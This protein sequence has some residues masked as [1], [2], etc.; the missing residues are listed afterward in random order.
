VKQHL[1]SK[2]YTGD[3]MYVIGYTCN[4]CQKNWNFI[5]EVLACINNHEVKEM[6]ESDIKKI[7]FYTLEDSSVA[8][9]VVNYIRSWKDIMETG[10][11]SR[12]GYCEALRRLCYAEV[13]ATV[14]INAAIHS[15][16]QVRGV[17]FAQIA[18]KK[19]IYSI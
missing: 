12:D 15:I 8:D 14:D 18:G 11:L 4:I 2:R 7:V 19:N 10:Q 16:L 13:S 17:A 9:A 5:Y 1:Y 6:P 3:N